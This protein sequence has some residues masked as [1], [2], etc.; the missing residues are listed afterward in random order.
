[1]S[2]E[3]PASP[4]I[5]CQT[6]SGCAGGVGGGARLSDPI[7]VQA[8]ATLVDPGCGSHP[9]PAENVEARRL[10]GLCTFWLGD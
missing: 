10:A 3:S 6:C 9:V 8:E 7:D 5:F 4:G 2:D 1:V